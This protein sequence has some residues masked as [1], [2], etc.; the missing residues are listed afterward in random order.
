MYTRLISL[1]K[2]INQNAPKKDFNTALQLNPNDIFTLNK[3]GLV[4]RKIA[5]EKDSG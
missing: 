5:E 3:R 4:Y 1:I 2:E